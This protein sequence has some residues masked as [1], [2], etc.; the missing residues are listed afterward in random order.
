MFLLS[1]NQNYDEEAVR[2]SNGR[3]L[4]TIWKIPTEPRK[5]SNGQDHHAVMA[6]ARRCVRMTSR[7]G[8]FVLDLYA[9]SGTMPLAAHGMDRVGVELKE[10][11]VRLIERRL[12]ES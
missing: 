4:R 5:R 7:A 8:D 9:G 6:L 10:K 3:R 11:Y 2:G 12:R 1:K